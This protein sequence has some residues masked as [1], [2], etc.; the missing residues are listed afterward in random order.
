MRNRADLI[1]AIKAGQKF[2]FLFFCSHRQKGAEIDESCLSQ[3]FPRPFEH[4]GVTYPTAE[5]FMMAGKARVFG[6]DEALAEVLA[7]KTPDEVKQIGRRV[8]DYDDAVWSAARFDIVVQGNLA[9]FGNKGNEDLRAFLLQTEGLVLVEAAF[10]DQIWGI[11]MRSTNADAKM[12]EL[13]QGENL[14]GF[15]LMEVRERLWNR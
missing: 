2:D 6:D 11:G 9:K 5:H 4:E 14:L 3:W 15:A 7:T 10:Y 1:S 13:W 8:K 12:P